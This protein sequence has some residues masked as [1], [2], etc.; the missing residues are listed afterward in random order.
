MAMENST[1]CLPPLRWIRNQPKPSSQIPLPD[2]D[3][4]KPLL[5]S[6]Q[7]QGVLN[8][9]PNVWADAH[10]ML[11]KAPIYTPNSEFVYSNQRGVY[12]GVVVFDYDAV[13]LGWK[14][15]GNNV[16]MDIC[17]IYAAIPARTLPRMYPSRKICATR[18]ETVSCDDGC[19]NRSIS[20]C[21]AHGIL[22]PF[23]V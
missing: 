3:I 12:H 6:S 18:P 7:R 8:S 5:Y 1:P 10:L 17:S 23:A 15:K 22:M 20:T 13:L 9:K 16:V 2:S 11:P 4:L 21:H 19:Q 14:F